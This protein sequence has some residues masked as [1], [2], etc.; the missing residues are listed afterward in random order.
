MLRG[1]I[2]DFEG[3]LVDFQWD[4]E[5]G[6]AEAREVLSE[7]FDEDLSGKNYAELY[8]MA[9][10]RGISRLLDSVYDRYDMDALSRWSLRDGVEEF[11]SL[12]KS[13]GLRLG[14]LSNVGFAA[15]RRALEKFGLFSFFD[16][17]VSRDSMGF[18]KPHPTSV[19]KMLSV[20]GLPPSDIIYVGDSFSDLAAANSYS[21]RV[22]I[23][24]LGEVRREEFEKIGFGNFINSFRELK[25]MVLKEVGI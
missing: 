19:E 12:S 21:I 15:L 7:F 20:L 5:R 18:L 23:I 24:P 14:L 6:E 2:L 25:E 11:L 10:E 3:T 8:N 17:I 1:I 4:L 13:L 9:A 16:A 22:Y